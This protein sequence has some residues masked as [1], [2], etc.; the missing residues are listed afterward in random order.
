[1]P[2]ESVLSSYE[3]GIVH[4]GENRRI[5]LIDF[6][7]HEQP[8]DNHVSQLCGEPAHHAFLLHWARGGIR[9]AGVRTVAPAHGE[10]TGR[11]CA[12]GDYAGRLEGPSYLNFTSQHWMLMYMAVP[13]ILRLRRAPAYDLA[14][15]HL[16]A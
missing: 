13:G 11:R 1:M 15:L 8:R 3:G 6:I 16:I 12:G 2:Q 7:Q 14:R 10:E 4:V 5:M 9:S